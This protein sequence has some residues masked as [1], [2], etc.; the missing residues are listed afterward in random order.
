[1]TKPEKKY[2]GVIVPMVTPLNHDL[3]I[4]INGVIKITDRF[5][6]THVAPFLLGT[7]GESV[8]LSENQQQEIVKTVV[9]R[10]NKRTIVYAGISGNCL[11][12]SIER[13]KKFTDFGVDAVVA[14]L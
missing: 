2:K 4:D 5:I 11:A 1:M 14:H 9:D 8:S 3:S 12:E 13:A 6:E 7:T 10:V